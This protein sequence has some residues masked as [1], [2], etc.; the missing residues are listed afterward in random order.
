[1][2]PLLW[3]SLGLLY[4]A[5]EL[6]I[7]SEFLARQILL[8][9][10]LRIKKEWLFSSLIFFSFTFPNF[11]QMWRRQSLREAGAVTGYHIQ[12]SLICFLSQISNYFHKTL[13]ESTASLRHYQ[14]CSGWLYFFKGRRWLFSS[15]LCLSHRSWTFRE[16]TIFICVNY[17]CHSFWNKLS[18]S[19]TG[20]H[21][22]RYFEQQR[23]MWIS[24]RIPTNHSFPR[25]V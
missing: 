10:Y 11:L 9:S 4:R 21:V 24:T 7:N 22:S 23:C 3:T 19:W 5:A 16:E 15:A 8:C 17:Q 20:E 13:I 6:S 14:K 18:T 2:C 12:F 25:K 1:M